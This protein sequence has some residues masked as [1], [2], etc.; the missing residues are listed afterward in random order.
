M[1]R[2]LVNGQLRYGSGGLQP[3]GQ[4]DINQSLR[5]FGIKPRRPGLVILISDLLSSSGH[6]QRPPH[7]Q[8]N[9]PGADQDAL[10]VRSHM[11]AP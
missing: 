9:G 10:Y 4:T 2:S 7:G 6:G 3:T 1:F 8:P 5:E 11:P